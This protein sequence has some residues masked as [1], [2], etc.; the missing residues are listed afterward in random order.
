MIG[1]DTPVLLSLLRGE[2]TAKALI[3]RLEAEEVGT[4]SINLFELETLARLDSSAGKEHRLAALDRL[5]RKLTILPIDD[6]SA[7]TAAGYASKDPSHTVPAAN[8]VILGA[9]EAHGCSEWV[10]LPGSHF[11]RASKSVRVTILGHSASK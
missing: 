10:T 7:A 2:S 4:T 8:W 9:L 3:R 6:R 11:P 1:L 5:R